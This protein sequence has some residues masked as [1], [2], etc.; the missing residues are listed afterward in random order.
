MERSH[1]V[2]A[3]YLKQFVSKSSKWDDW[4]ELATFSYNTSI[5]EETRCSPYEL[6]FGKLA[7]QPSSEPLPE[8]KKLETYDDYL[9]KLVTRIHEIR[10][11]ARDNL[12]AAK[13]KSK[14]CYDRNISPQNFNVDEEVFLLS[15]PK[16]K[17]LENQYS[18]PYKILEVLGKGNVKIQIKNKPKVV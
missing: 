5:H 6:V 17:K 2:L 10:A 13:E 14:K 7:R 16:P 15:G 3:E 12:I 8:H 1:H 11:I 9:I 4:I 18:G